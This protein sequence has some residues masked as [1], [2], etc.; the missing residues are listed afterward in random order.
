[1]SQ[2]VIQE[3]IHTLRSF[4]RHP[5]EEVAR[6]PEWSLQRTLLT[7]ATL[8]AFSGFLAGLFPPGIWRIIQGMILFPF[9]VTVMG[10]LLASF[11]YYYFQIFE[12]RTVAYGKLLT[13][14][15][16]C[17]FPFFLFHIASA[18]FAPSD[19]FGLAMMSILLVI[20]L[21]E[22]F[23][24]QKRRS[25]RLIGVIFGL[26]F[27]IWLGERISYSRLPDTSATNSGETVTL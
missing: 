10:A 24:L 21:T 15:A 22:N 5:L 8:A 25:I 6:I 18:L 16:F 7:Q 23:G 12:R 20:G 2:V 19:L 1:M 4:F 9:L 13:L 11:F 26:L 27:L 17:S 3:T 14:I